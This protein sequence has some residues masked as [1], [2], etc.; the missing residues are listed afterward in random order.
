MG[1]N[2]GAG[3][4]SECLQMFHYRQTCIKPTLKCTRMTLHKG[5]L[6][7]ESSIC[8]QLWTGP[9]LPAVPAPVWWDIYTHIP[10]WLLPPQAAGR[11]TNK[12][13][14][15]VLDWPRHY[16]C[17]SRKDIFS[18][19]AGSAPG[20]H[21]AQPRLAFS[22]CPSHSFSQLLICPPP[23]GEGRLSAPGAPLERV[24]STVGPC[25][26]W[27][28]APSP[29][30]D[31]TWWEGAGNSETFGVWGVKW[32]FSSILLPQNCCW[33][34]YVIISMNAWKVGICF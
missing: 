15:T 30:P 2:R 9:V 6:P 26:P 32:T 27:G 16:L 21:C 29:E 19:A 24:P 13:V 4:C 28:L 18:S 23:I 7:S 14:E 1:L 25:C 34:S 5:A 11:H 22:A 17:P 10:R 33:L 20:A 12:R 8:D 3:K 31:P